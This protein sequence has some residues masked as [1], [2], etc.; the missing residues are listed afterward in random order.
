LYALPKTKNKISSWAL[1]YRYVVRG[2]EMKKDIID[3]VGG[4]PGLS[5][6]VGANGVGKTRVLDEIG[7]VLDNQYM[8]SNN[9]KDVP[10]SGSK[11][12][13]FWVLCGFVKGSNDTG[14]LEQLNATVK[15]IATNFGKFEPHPTHGI[16]YYQK[17]SA[18]YTS[19]SHALLVDLIS[20]GILNF[21]AA[22]AIAIL[23]V[24][25]RDDDER[26]VILI[27]DVEQGLHPSALHIVA[28]MLRVAAKKHRVIVTTH[29]PLLL[30]EF[31]PK[32]IVVL[33]SFDE[34]PNFRVL[35]NED[36]AGW[37][38]SDYSLGDLWLKNILGG[39]P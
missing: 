24:L 34:E 9:D 12:G 37:L 35:K 33:D 17:Q 31:E 6:I 22:L 21:M 27:D 32:N 8:K 15:L 36:Y 7:R 25:N 28:A 16:V 11:G 26:R 18:A 30:N 1:G 2:V 29:S 3:F 4:E 10:I 20:A 14:R 19:L 23:D 39:R 5:I 13:L 38:D